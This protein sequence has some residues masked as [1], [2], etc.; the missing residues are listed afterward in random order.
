VYA[1]IA[2]GGKQ[3][4]VQEGA[5]LAVE[6]L[7]GAEGD[8]VTFAPILLV[9]GGTTLATPAELNGATVGARIVG[10][11]KGPKI[12]GLTYTPKARTRK[13]WG[14]RQHYTT[15]EITSI[16]APG[17][18]AAGPSDAAEAAGPSGPSEREAE[19]QG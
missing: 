5:R 9:D 8:D 18:A 17:K 6:K 1:V 3:H 16:A 10:E 7:T 4:R 14:H 13:R 12:R 2:T 15:I 19:E 11:E